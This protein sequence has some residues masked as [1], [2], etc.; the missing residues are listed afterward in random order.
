VGVSGAVVGGAALVL[1]GTRLAVG[2]DWGGE[3]VTWSSLLV[4]IAAIILA[5]AS[6][7]H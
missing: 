2:K 7:S 3:I 4:A 1:L 5:I 6:T